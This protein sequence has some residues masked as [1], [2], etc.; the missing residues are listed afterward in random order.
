MTNSSSRRV[1][2]ITKALPG[3]AARA[4]LAALALT[5][6]FAAGAARA[7]EPPC[8]L[9]GVEPV[10]VIEQAKAAFLRGDYREFYRA[11]TPYVPD[12]REQFPTLMGPVAMLFP[13]GFLHCSTILQRRDAGGMVQEITMFQVPAPETGAVSIILTTAPFKDEP[14]VI[15][16]VF[17]SA[18]GPVLDELR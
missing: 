7:D 6:L 11:V 13:D 16:F 12:A 15:A 10:P 14:E 4:T 1:K 5:G 18:I 8:A 3:P 9:N 17:N 2:V